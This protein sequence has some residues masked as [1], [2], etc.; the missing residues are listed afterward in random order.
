MTWGKG[1][2]ATST[3]LGRRLLHSGGTDILVNAFSAFLNMAR[4]EKL[5]S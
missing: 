5:G 2:M 1:D 4:C 3:Q